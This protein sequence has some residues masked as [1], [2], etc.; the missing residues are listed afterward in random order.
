MKIRTIILP[1]LLSASLFGEDTLKSSLKEVASTQKSSVQSQS[2]IDKIDDQRSL[3]LQE[4][5]ALL[6]EI[7]T[8]KHYNGQLNSIVTSQ[9]EEIDSLN[10]Q[11]ITI[12]VTAGQIM[13]LMDQMIEALTAFTKLDMPF[14]PDERQ[15]RVKDLQVLLIRADI[16][17]S[18]KYRKI[19]EAY[20]IESDFGHTIEAY[21]NKLSQK[22]L[23]RDVDFLR[24]GRIGLFYRTFD[25]NEVGFFNKESQSFEV[26]D[27]QYERSIKKAIQVAKKRKAPELFILP[28]QIPKNVK[29]EG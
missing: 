8:V 27:H 7:E 14:L 24:I 28:L 6:V 17:V 11:I 12:D 1:L 4:Y 10:D 16:S 9:K 29:L 2:K 18:E 13:P 25:G 23:V 5:R 3:L 22:D 20:S 19:V 26:L 15:K 21:R